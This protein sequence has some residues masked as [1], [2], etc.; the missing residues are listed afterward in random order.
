MTYQCCAPPAS[1]CNASAQETRIEVLLFG[2]GD[3][4][5]ISLWNDKDGKKTTAS[6]IR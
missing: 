2:E 3:I 4:A 6:A 5:M 1:K